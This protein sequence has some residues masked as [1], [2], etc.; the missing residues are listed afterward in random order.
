MW[1]AVCLGDLFVDLVPHSQVDG[2][3]L[4]LP[5]PGGAPGNVAAGLA[6]LDH[7][8]LMISR[9][10]A[11]AFGRL[12]IDALAGYG[13][14]VSGVVQSST[15]QSGLSIVTLDEAGDRSFMFHHDRP[16]DQHIR[17]EDLKAEW[18]AGTQVLHV[19]ILP[20]ASP[21][22]AAAQRW[23]MDLADASGIAISC[24]VN[25]RPS[26]WQNTDGMLA[27]GQE[28]LSRSSIV[29]L[30]EEE[31]RAVT[32]QDDLASGLKS[33]WHDRLR[34]CSITRGANGAELHAAGRRYVCH[35]FEVD[36]VDT[37]GAGD[38]YTAAIL[39][40]VLKGAAAQELLDTACAAG[41]LAAS[42]KGAMKSL[43]T[44]SELETFLSTRRAAVT[45]A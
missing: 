8:V 10:G 1:D 16:A 40:G 34:Y 36:A 20:L 19:G 17:A 28:V 41:A 13:V 43:P 38:A 42:R 11:D 39:S 15:E 5:S 9:V 30:S 32:E 23:A 29:K 37:T 45:L 35:G 4:Y 2:E 31:L 3:W 25:F 18:L 33:I 24:D 12:L 6:K 26:L 44:R 21:T 22:A 14:D 27:A 7:S